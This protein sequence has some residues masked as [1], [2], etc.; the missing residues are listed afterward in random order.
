MLTAPVRHR[1]GSG[2]L[3][4]RS[5]DVHDA[6]VRARAA[7]AG[8]EDLAH[9]EER[10]AAVA[11]VDGVALAEALPRPGAARVEPPHRLVG[12]GVERSSVRRHVDPR[13][14]REV[15]RR[16]TQP[17]QV[18]ARGTNLGDVG[19]A[20]GDQHL[21]VAQRRD[22]RIPAPLGHVR[23]KAPRVRLVVEHVCLDDPVQPRVQV[24]AREEECPIGQVSQTAAEDVEARVHPHRRLGPG[25]GIPQGGSG[26]VMHRVGLGCVVANRVVGQHLAIGQQRHVHTDDGPVDQRA[27]ATNLVLVSRDGRLCRLGVGRGGGDGLPLEPPLRGRVVSDRV[28]RLVP[29]NGVDRSR[30]TE[31][32]CGSEDG[33]R[34]RHKGG[35]KDELDAS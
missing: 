2:H 17:P 20:L 9:I 22:R 10:V 32:A 1:R 12:T 23:A 14:Q 30:V 26:V 6:G 8:D 15:Q 25:V 28:L 27:P 21:A 19:A 16:R 31:R 24:P 18:P 7:A 13:I 3:R 4:R 29:A 5:A 33:Y 34:R 11:A 35:E